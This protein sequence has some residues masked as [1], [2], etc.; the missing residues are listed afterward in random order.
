MIK[1]ASMETKTPPGPRSFL[2]L[3]FARA[4][5]RDVFG[6]SMDLARRYGDAAYFRI[7]PLRFFQFTHPAQV[8]EVLVKQAKKLHK[9]K[10]VKEVFGRW[11]GQGLLLSEGDLWVRQRRLVQ[12]AFQPRRVEGYAAVMAQLAGEM[13]ARWQSRT[14]IDL[15]EAMH[16]VTLDIVCKTLFGF[17]ADDHAGIRDAVQDLQD[18]ALLEFGRLMPV[19]D[20]LPIA[21]KRRMRAAI[22]YM[23]HLLDTI[24]RQHHEA[25]QDRGD[26]LSMLLL[27][28]DHEG[29]GRGMSHQQVRDE[30]MTLLLAGHETT[31]TTLVWTLYLLARHP[32]A[33]EQAAA[34]VREVLG[35]RPPTA[36]DVPRLTAIDCAIKEAM[37]LYPAVYFT[38][39][40]AAEEV[41]IGGYQIPPGSQIH[42]LL[43]AMYHDA[44]WF[45][46]PEEFRPQRFAGGREEQLPACAFVPFGA[47]PRVCI[48]RSMAM[49]EATL[50]VATVLQKYRLSLAPGQAE[51][52]PVA[53]V[54]LHPAGPVRLVLAPRISGT[55]E[56]RPVAQQSPRAQPA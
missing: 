1:G 6:F 8:Q 34:A 30:A 27:S 41:E 51:P 40:E 46:E 7:G 42:L 43:Y 24:I 33:Q 15:V 13:V 17:T 53:Q 39:R 26:L 21:S 22:R 4:M 16:S 20:W 44:R 38:S 50:I 45:A 35:D 2:G 55:S 5:Q 11:D 47:G 49:I 28:V 14:E 54:S 3:K 9:P 10:R 36:A 18:A 56:P 25:G 12:Q 31:A 23:N 37:R 29:D 52:T 48:G 32:Q 19:P